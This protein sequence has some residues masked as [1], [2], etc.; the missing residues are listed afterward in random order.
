MGFA[1]LRFDADAPAAEAWSDALLEAGAL[2]VDLADPDLGTAREQAIYGEPGLE[3]SAAWPM[4]RVTA[5]FADAGSVAAATVASAMQLGVPFPAH[6]VFEVPDQ[7]WVRATQA[8]FTPI[9][10]EGPLW[11]VPSWAEPVD[12][13]AVNLV[14]DPGLAFGTGSH[15]TTRL[16]LRWLVAARLAGCAVLDYGCGSGIL[17]I[18]A[19]RLGATAVT[20]IDIDPQAVLSSQA[21]AARNGVPDATFATPGALPKGAAFDVVLA[22]ILANPLVLLAPVLARRVRPGGA[23]LLSGV[24]VGQAA[25][26]VAA[27]TPWFRMTAW[28]EDDGWVAL[29]G[30]RLG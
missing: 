20:G 14:L 7:D 5:L 23:L 2:S 28:N 1:A 11:I 3:A 26:V 9:H 19:A 16:C 6:A 17:A 22:N 8:Q 29:A 18:A 10:V 13:S 15:P 4:T 24:L 25:E 27:Y 30:D 21:N 12:L